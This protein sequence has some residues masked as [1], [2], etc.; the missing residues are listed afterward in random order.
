MV[1]LVV[2]WALSIAAAFVVADRIAEGRAEFLVVHGVVWTALVIGPM[3][4]CG[5][6]NVLT[7]AVVA[8]VTI[9]VSLSAVLLTAGGY[10]AERNKQLRQR[11]WSMLRIPLDAMRIT[12]RGNALLAF[13]LAIAMAYYVW[14]LISAYLAP[15]WGDWDALW[16]HEPIVAFSIQN[17]GFDPVPLPLV[18][19]L[20]NGYQRFGEV[21]QTWWGLFAGRRVLDFAQLMFIPMYLGATHGLAA[22]FTRDK[23]IP[24]AWAAALL[25][26]PGVS[27]QLRSSMVDVE[28][29]ALLLAAIYF[30]S[31]PTL[32]RRRMVLFL[33]AVT[34]AVGTKTLNV[35]LGGLACAVFAVR[36]LVQRRELGRWWVGALG[37]GGGALVLSMLAFT[38]LRNW[39]H[40][41]NPLWPVSLTVPSLGIDWP[42]AMPYTGSIDANMPFADL[43]EKLLTRPYTAAGGHTWHVDDYGFGVAWILFPLGAMACL[44]APVAWLAMTAYARL[45]KRPPSVA[46][47]TA[48]WAALVALFAIAGY[49]LSPSVHVPRYM[50]APIAC[51]C[52]ASCWLLQGRAWRRGM[53]VAVFTVEVSGILMTYWSISPPMPPRDR[54]WVYTPK[55]ILDMMRTPYPL[56]EVARKFRAPVNEPVA[57]AREEEIGRGDVVMFDTNEPWPA[58]AW[59]NDL[60]NKVYWIDDARDAKTQ[61]DERNAK[62]VLTRYGSA[63]AGQLVAAGWT[64]VGGIENEQFTTAY[65][66]PR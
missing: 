19:Q 56:R 62:W 45:K 2:L 42:G 34:G 10:S 54:I 38:H 28:G 46:A 20:I 31:H 39:M 16:Y 9:L 43:V 40:F 61:V 63:L 52:A 21:T 30:V 14:Q 41:K 32:T 66:H 33:F 47:K 29:G 3:Y 44:A 17:H 24:I 53:H 50:L 8:P 5:L 65:R 15:A 51:A 12:L 55:E 48:G 26:M 64:V 23:A 58:M 25:L 27:R 6:C 13:P 60:S 18:H 4:V 59:N 57:L 1:L 22:R 36:V 49:R 35:P 7:R 37:L 11:V